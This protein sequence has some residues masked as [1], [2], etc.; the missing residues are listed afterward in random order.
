L[1]SNAVDTQKKEG[2][3][4]EKPLI[5]AAIAGNTA[6]NRWEHILPATKNKKIHKNNNPRGAEL[7]E[8]QLFWICKKVWK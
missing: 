8:S 7:N 1:Q 5:P 3:A 2:A 4:E 6:D